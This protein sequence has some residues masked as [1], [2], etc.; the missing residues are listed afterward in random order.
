LPQPAVNLP[1]ERF[2][3]SRKW[4]RQL[5]TKWIFDNTTVQ[6]ILNWGGKKVSVRKM[7]GATLEGI[8]SFP[9]E[10]SSAKRDALF[11]GKSLC[12]S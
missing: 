9:S 8:H 11:T 6:R 7:Y 4:Y 10:A 12:D 5:H 2:T 3:P 1:K